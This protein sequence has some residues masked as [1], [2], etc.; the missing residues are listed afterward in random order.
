MR[1]KRY[2][3]TADSINHTESIIQGDSSSNLVKGER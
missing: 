1:N 2:V 3:L